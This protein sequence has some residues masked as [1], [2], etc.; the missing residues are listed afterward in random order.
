MVGAGECVKKYDKV[1]R[2]VFTGGM[3]RV[4]RSTDRR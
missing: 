1:Y 3:E 2:E 4:H